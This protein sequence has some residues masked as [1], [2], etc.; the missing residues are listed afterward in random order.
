[1]TTALSLPTLP[2]GV[3][4][5][6]YIPDLTDTADIQQALKLLYYGSTASANSANGI[7]GALTGLKNYVDASISGVNVH[8]TVKYATTTTIAGVYAA[9]TADSSGGTGI[10]A[11]ITFSS[12][13]VQSIDSGSNLAL[14][15]RVLVKDGVTADSGINSKANGIYYV[16]T[17]PAVGV[18]GV[19]TRAEDSNNSVAGEMGEGDFTFVSGGTTNGNTSWIL[20]SSSPTGTGPAGAI[21]IG[22][23]PVTFIQFGSVT[24][25]S[26]TANTFF[27]APNGSSGT[28]SFR[29]IGTADLSTYGTLTTSGQVLQWTTGLNALT[30]SSAPAL[31]TSGGT[32][33]GQLNLAAGTTSIVPL[34][35]NT[36]GALI[37]TSA[38]G[39][40][41][42]DANSLYYTDNP[43]TTTTGAGRGMVHASQMVFSLG[44]ST[45][46][47]TTAVSVFAA[48]N[49]VL[50]VLEPAKLYRFKAKYL[51]TL[52][53]GG[54]AV[55]P[56]INF[57]FSNAPTAI[58][59]TFKTYPQTAA[60][61]TTFAGAAAVTTATAI[62]P[63]LSATANYFV[64][65]DGYFTT[66]AT[67][68][69]TF[70]PQC[71]ATAATSGSTLSF[72]SGSWLEVEK[73]GTS[74]QTLI[75]GNWA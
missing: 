29:S 56:T 64:E 13:G 1:M 20:T 71:A 27:A 50:S 5:A 26:Q 19:L 23:D 58:K 59:Y 75:A 8:E 68:T 42:A 37:T 14:N 39:Y 60:A 66:H 43:G 4:G 49:D 44:T 25:G 28:P 40:V 3:T 2:S 52:T 65:I 9:G 47:S 34:N 69:S 54:T 63:S 17:A 70:T 51:I 30:W 72:V 10:G 15:D 35:F 12:T 36:T 6:S 57:L 62:T 74:T 48:A 7:Y 46:T 16:T 32:L 11:K 53:Y 18:A 67:L 22:T 41:E 21:K 45:P 31:F 55:T 73:L 24:W 61:S 38:S 33:T